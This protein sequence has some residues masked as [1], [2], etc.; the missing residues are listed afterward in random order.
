MIENKLT[1]KKLIAIQQY[2]WYL[3]V[4]LFAVVT[5]LYFL[6]SPFAQT[7]ALAGVVFILTATLLKL[8]VMAEKFRA[9]KLNRLVVMSYI[10]LALLIST[11]VLRYII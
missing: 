11:I 9:A 7:L 2:S 5:L 8:I 3:A 4:I 6:K 10:L 1:D